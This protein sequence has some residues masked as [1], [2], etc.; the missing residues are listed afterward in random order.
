MHPSIQRLYRSLS[1][2]CELPCEIDGMQIVW[3]LA[4]GDCIAQAVVTAVD[5]GRAVDIVAGGSGIAAVHNH[6]VEP[7]GLLGCNLEIEVAAVDL[8]S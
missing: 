8:A 7:T 6:V 1:G 3:H 5:G 2:V 4:E